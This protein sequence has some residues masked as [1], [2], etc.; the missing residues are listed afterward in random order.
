MNPLASTAT[1]ILS[2]PKPAEFGR[3][4]TATSTFSNVICFSGTSPSSVT[5]TPPLASASL[6]T[7]VFKKML[8]NSF[9]SRA[10]S[11]C[12]RSGSTPGNRFGVSSTTVTFVPRAA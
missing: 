11:G 1:P 6:A 2:S 7:F 5:W 4:P 9:L 12:T 3:R 10:C 8:A